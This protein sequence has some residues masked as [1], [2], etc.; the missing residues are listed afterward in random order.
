MDI[1]FAE[2]AALSRSWTRCSDEY[3]LDAR[4]DAPPRVLAR[5]ELS[6][7][8]EP[9]EQM[10]ANCAEELDRLYALLRPIGYAMALAEPGGAIVFSRGH[11][12]HVE[13]YQTLGFREGA[14][15]S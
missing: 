15:W 11:E 7:R 13:R 12:A 6:G 4:Y 9:V 2:T 10:L 1:H 14:L 3:R 8:R 5:A